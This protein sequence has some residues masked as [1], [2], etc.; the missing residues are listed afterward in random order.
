MTD[1]D[2]V[3]RVS[4]EIADKHSR[5]DG[6]IAAAGIQQ[7]TPALE[8]SVPDMEKM[9][10]VNYTGVFTSAK[11]AARQ[12]IKYDCKG[13]IV[14]IASISGLI[15]N[16]GLITPVYNS[17]KAAVIQLGRNL[18]MEW[19]PMGIRVNSIC[20]GGLLP[21]ITTIVK[22]T[23]DQSYRSLHDSN[24][25]QELRRRAPPPSIMGGSKHDEKTWSSKRAQST[26]S[27]PTQRCKLVHDGKRTNYR[28]WSYCLVV[29]CSMH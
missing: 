7:V 20:P 27:V 8:Y 11:A 6:L 26:G 4:A 10:A 15:A 24:G 9:L 19:A 17:S 16:V 2:N 3:E 25:G 23:Y 12:M 13:S 1:P 18:A 29:Y 21:L 22:Y 14:L 5:M 28:W